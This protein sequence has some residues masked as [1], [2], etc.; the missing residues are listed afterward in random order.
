M[1]TLAGNKQPFHPSLPSQDAPFLSFDRKW[2]VLVRRRWT[3]KCLF[4]RR[5]FVY[6]HDIRNFLNQQRKI[7]QVK[8]KNEEKKLITKYMTSI[9]KYIQ[10]SFSCSFDHQLILLSF[11][12][13]EMRR[14]Q[15]HYQ[16]TPRSAK[17]LLVVSGTVPQPLVVL[18]DFK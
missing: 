7:N 6:N 8:Q 12:S 1:P 2:T 14:N 10:S 4:P 13:L 15:Q 11:Q 9:Q 3:S 16:F 18:V 17:Q 5:H